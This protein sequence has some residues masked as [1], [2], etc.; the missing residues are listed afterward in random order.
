MLDGTRSVMD[1]QLDM[2]RRQGG[3][4]IP[5]EEIERIVK[6]LESSCLLDGHHYRELKEQ[7]VNDFRS[8]PIRHPAH[9]GL[10]YPEGAEELR[11]RL[12]DIL[13]AGQHP[14]VPEGTITAL[15]APHI[16]LEAGK[17]VYAAAY[18]SVGAAAPTRILILGV[19]HA[20]Q[21]E[22]FSLTTKAFETP[23]GTVDTDRRVVEELGKTGRHIISS[24]DF[25][26]RDEHSIEFQLLFLQH[27]FNDSP[28]TIVPVLC[29]SLLG[30]M[31]EYSR[32]SYRSLAGDFLR[33]LQDIAGDGHTMVVAGVDFSHV[34]P[35]FGHD[36]P[37]SF[38]IG[39]SEAHDRRLLH[40]LCEMNADGF[41]AASQDVHDRY[42]VCGFSALACL[43]EIL[44][45]S[46]GHLLDYTIFREQATQSAVSF[47]AVLFVG[48]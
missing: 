25:P 31:E 33:L 28:F 8:Q 2:M 36:M 23:L 34:G 35:K 43:L 38:M 29:G 46:H 48:S 16:D 24:D 30:S 4:L 6:E 40:C 19:G 7:I 10:S 41:W 37:A 27:L 17:R 18:A 45:A 15:V 13:A 22:M 20:M 9:A 42:H 39:Q 47:A 5:I 32:E 3:R 14:Q 11:S 26:H 21:R 12:D 44:P 1:I